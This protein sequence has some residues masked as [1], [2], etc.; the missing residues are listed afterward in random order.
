MPP[1]TP[2]PPAETAMVRT[3]PRTIRVPG[4]P[5]EGEGNPAALVAVLTGRQFLG[6]YAIT[7]AGLCY[8]ASAQVE[9]TALLVIAGVA[10]KLIDRVRVLRS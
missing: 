7:F 8:M 1:S 2:D 3:E 4:P 10:Y 9:A 6:L 5:T